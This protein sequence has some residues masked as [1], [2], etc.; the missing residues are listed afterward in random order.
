MRPQW[1]DEDQIPFDQMWKDDKHWLPHL[2]KNKYVNAYFLFK[3]DQETIISQ[4]MQLFDS[5]EAWHLSINK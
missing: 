3:E 5:Q 1:F 2:I 4:S